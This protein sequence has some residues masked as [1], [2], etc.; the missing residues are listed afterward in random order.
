M[1]QSNKELRVLST[2]RADKLESDKATYTGDLQ[3]ISNYIYPIGDVNNSNTKEAESEKS[4]RRK[5]VHNIGER[6]VED[7]AGYIQNTLAPVGMNWIMLFPDDPKLMDREPLVKWLDQAARRTQVYLARPEVKFHLMFDE[8]LIEAIATGTGV[9]QLLERYN[10]KTKSKML[11]FKSASVTE[12]F[13]E[14]NTWGDID[15][16]FR[17]RQMTARQIL[18]DYVND[19]SLATHDLDVEEIKQLTEDAQA[20]PNKKFEVLQGYFPEDDIIYKASGCKEPYAS[21][22]LFRD[23]AAGPNRRCGILRNSGMTF[24]P[25]IPFRFRKRA[26]ET[27]GFGP[28][29]RVLSDIISLQRMKRTNLRCAELIEKPPLHIPF[30]AY[31]KQL[32]IGPGAANHA[33]RTGSN[34]ENMA[35][36]LLVIGNVPIG[37][38]MEDRCVEEIRKGMYLDKTQ[39]TKNAEMSATESSIRERQNQQALSPQT[40]RIVTEFLNMVLEPVINYL[41]DKNMIDPM[42]KE[43]KE[44]GISPIYI[45]QLIRAQADTDLIGLERLSGILASL[46]GA[47]PNIKD[48]IEDTNIPKMIV[49]RLFLPRDLLRDQETVANEREQSKAMDQTVGLAGAAKD[50]S[51][52]SLNLAKTADM[53]GV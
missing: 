43:L 51:Q 18:Q 53:L 47:F 27:Y 11:V 26:G 25:Y 9:P 29:S 22:H 3:E 32:N 31:T 21:I 48:S 7:L 35:Q 17:V 33:K 19:E 38:E 1:E 5:I 44:S 4:R 49:Q 23:G 40:Y 46:S 15:R 52:G 41:I 34:K 37:V 50:A 13:F 36:P 45:S 24:C 20:N 30:Q 8:V 10:G 6:C 2:T 12:C 42:P 16:G 39:E 28:G 14:E